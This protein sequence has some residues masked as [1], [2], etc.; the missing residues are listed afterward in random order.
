M[1]VVDNS[2]C[3]NFFID[4]NEKGKVKEKGKGRKRCEE[5]E[6]DLILL[7]KIF[8]HQVQPIMEFS[9]RGYFPYV[10]CETWTTHQSKAIPELMEGLDDHEEPTLFLCTPLSQGGISYEM[11]A[12]F[13]KG[14]CNE[15][16]YNL[17]FRESMKNI[18][19]GSL[20]E[21]NCVVRHWVKKYRA[22][23]RWSVDLEPIV[24][25]YVTPVCF[26]KQKRWRKKI[27][28]E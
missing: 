9:S 7:K 2:M 10:F 17:R 4:C 11:K 6:E 23:N 25:M 15:K 18:L 19:M 13:I 1:L 27:V 21:I 8:P 3:T 16:Y 24:S 14:K 12:H 28:L 5:D 26:S 22:T 20:R